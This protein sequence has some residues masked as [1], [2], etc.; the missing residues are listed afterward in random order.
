MTAP[1]LA[2]EEGRATYRAELK[3]VAW[4]LRLG[5]LVLIVGAAALIL[6][7]REGWIGAF[8]L[9][10][11]AGYVMLGLGWALFIAAIF[12]RTRYHKRRMA[13]AQ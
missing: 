3:R 5:G 10:T 4:P 6:A 11:N 12:V 8:E 7:A 9:A 13:E 2:T 1:D